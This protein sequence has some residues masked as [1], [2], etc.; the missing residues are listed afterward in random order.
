[1]SVCISLLSLSLSHGGPSGTM[2][3]WCGRYLDRAHLCV[4]QAHHPGRGQLQQ[5]VGHEPERLIPWR[6][7]TEQ[8]PLLLRLLLEATLALTA[9]P[10]PGC[11]LE[12]GVLRHRQRNSSASQMALKMGPQGFHL[13]DTL[14][15]GPGLIPQRRPPAPAGQLCL[16]PPPTLKP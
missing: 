15:P 4:L 10:F 1:M 6:L 16:P 9:H 11:A 8:L 5:E 2:T 7:S 13:A 14:C 12:W 3:G